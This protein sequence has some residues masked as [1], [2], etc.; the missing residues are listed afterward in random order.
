MIARIAWTSVIAL[1]AAAS[2]D[3]RPLADQAY[4]GVSLRDTPEGTVVGWV[5]PGPFHGSGMESPTLRRS[6]LLV[7]A[8]G[9]K[10]DAPGFRTLLEGLNVGEDLTLVVKRGEKSDAHGAVPRGDPGGKELA[11]TVKLESRDAWTGTLGRG[12][13]PGAKTPEPPK[14]EFEDRILA[15]AAELDLRAADADGGKLD[16]LLAYLGDVQAKARDAFVLPA[17]AEGFRRPMSVDAAERGIADL[18]RSAADGKP[19]HVRALLTRV[20]GLP[21][22]DAEHGWTAAQLAQI[23]RSRDR[24]E[25]DAAGRARAMKLVRSL[26]DDVTIA[27]ED[28]SEKIAVMRDALETFEGLGM[29]ELERWVWSMGEIERVLGPHAHDAPMRDVPEDI[30]A[31]VQGDVLYFERRGGGAVFVVG[32]AGK[33]TYDMSK[34]AWVYDVGGDD[35]YVF[36]GGESAKGLQERIVVDLAGNDLYEGRGDFAGPG[37]GVFGM[38]TIDDRGGNDVY[39]SGGQFGIAAG[40]FGVG[41]IIDHAGDDRYENMG[42]ASGWSQGVGVYGAGVVID[43]G[44]SDA[45]LGEKL[46]QGVGGPHGFGA[47]IDA[48]GN[49]LYRADGPS[50]GSAYGTPGVFLSMSQGFGYGARGYA[51][52]GVGAIFDLAGDDRYEA[53]EFSQGCGYAWGMGLIHDFGGNDTYHGN[54][55]SQ[56]AAAHQAIG[57]LVDDGGNDSYWS[58]TAASQSGSWDQSITMLIDRAGNDAYRCDGLGQGA[59]AQQALAVLIDLGGTDHYAAAGGAGGAG[60]QGCSGGNEYHYSADK[61]LSFSMLMDVGNT[62]GATD[63]FS[64]GRAGSVR[65]GARDRVSPERSNLFGA[66]VHE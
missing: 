9:R 5:L 11:F 2:A 37:V 59:A 60:V 28:A 42:P 4:C 18:A 47:I 31:A 53:G 10:V 30:R 55:Y 48:G 39:K 41:I 56:A 26:R 13:A 23:H 52:G 40:L 51:S 62:P 46:C 20:L 3:E 66:F 35:A 45:Y 44:G 65:T 27:G 1:A 36:S 61:L 22:Q 17:I 33:N 54:R 12:S 7:S 49:D 16:A 19:E 57:M 32:G 25:T 63:W 50:F 14:G 29:W 15:A 43:M 24:W 34:L 64:T 6:D 38:C 58:M 21:T 8:N